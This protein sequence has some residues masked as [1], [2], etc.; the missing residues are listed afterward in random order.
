MINKN[1]MRVLSRLEIYGCIQLNV[2]MI[3]F[4]VTSNEIFA[5]VLSGQQRSSTYDFWGKRKKNR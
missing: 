4:T 3:S 2:S 1:N 5:F